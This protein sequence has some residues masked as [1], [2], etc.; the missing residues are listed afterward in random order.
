M[1]VIE[2]PLSALREAPWNPNRMDQPMLGRLRESLSRYGLVG[3]LVVRSL[4]DGQYEV[5]S[6][7]QR[8]KVLRENGHA[9]VPCVVLDLD[10]AHTRL[11]AQ[12]LNHI[13][14]E[15]DLGLRAELLRE[16]LA[17]LPQEEV[18]CLLPETAQSLQALASLGQADLAQH[19]Q[20]WQQAQGARLRHFQAQ[21]TPAQLEVVEQA[22]APFLAGVS[23]GE[24]GNPN[25]RGVALYMLCLAYLNGRAV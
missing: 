4:G 8:L 14:G 17:A 5:L 6:G 9:T 10:D 23:G 12:A 1:K 19:L 20:A 11:L 24:G 13:G 18:L 16:V 15:D 22:L 2:L 3:N 7:N 25:R 21:L